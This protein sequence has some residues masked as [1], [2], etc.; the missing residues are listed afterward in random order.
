M[1]INTS[2][3]Y[4]W[5]T[6]LYDRVGDLLNE[7][8]RSGAIDASAQFTEEMMKNLDRAMDHPDMT[9]ELAALLSM[10]QVEL[11]YEIQSGVNI[12]D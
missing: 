5:R 4:E 11:E 8:T 12:S 9:P 1:R 10:S 7:S 2:D 6:D 3:K